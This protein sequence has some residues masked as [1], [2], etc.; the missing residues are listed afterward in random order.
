MYLLVSFNN[1]LSSSI[2]SIQSSMQLFS[3]H[4]RKV[5]ITLTKEQEPRQFFCLWQEIS[6]C[7]V[8]QYRNDKISVLIHSYSNIQ[9]P[10]L[11]VSKQ[12]SSLSVIATP[13]RLTAAVWLYLLKSMLHFLWMLKA[14]KNLSLPYNKPSLLFCE[15][16]PRAISNAL[17]MEQ[18]LV[19]L[20]SLWHVWPIEKNLPLLFHV[21]CIWKP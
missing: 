5:N 18:S 19:L 14:R 8:W 20:L 3:Q 11:L 13:M 9:L 4:M 17:E 1:S 16:G 12:C 2:N 6:N 21:F 10:I 15:C 7:D